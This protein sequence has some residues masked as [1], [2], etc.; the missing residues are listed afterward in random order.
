MHAINSAADVVIRA[1]ADRAQDRRARGENLLLQDRGGGAGAGDDDDD[2]A[3]ERGD[4]KDNEDARQDAAPPPQP[5]LLPGPGG[6][7][8]PEDAAF[9]AA[10]HAAVELRMANG[11]HGSIV[12]SMMREGERRYAECM[13]AIAACNQNTNTDVLLMTTSQFKASGDLMRC[14]KLRMTLQSS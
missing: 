10:A 9:S 6:G 3:E 7:L 12:Q 11:Q 5:L 13:A 4:V 8:R 14:K 2:E 1:A